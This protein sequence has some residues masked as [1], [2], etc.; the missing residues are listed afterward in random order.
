MFAHR[1]IRHLNRS[2][3]ALAAAVLVAAAIVPISLAHAGAAAT[4]TSPSVAKHSGTRP[5]IVLVHGAWADASSWGA[6]AAELQH[7][8]FTVD[9]APNPLRGLS[10][11]SGYLKDYLATVP[12]PI[13]LVGHS[14]GGAVITDAAKGNKKVKALVYD[15]AYIPAKGENVATLSGAD[16]AL[17]PATTDPTKVFK[18]APYP[19]APKGI[20]DTYVLPNVFIKGLA[21]DLPRKEAAV[22]AASQSPTSLLALGEPSSAPAWKTIPSWDLVGKQDRIIP[23]AQQLMMAHRAGSHIT[24]INSSHLSLISHPG[25]VTKVILRAIHAEG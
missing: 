12:G 9:V 23:L 18:L 5:T 25:A 20:Y 7:K 3:G 4:S 2:S 8:G 24:E 21:G 14:Y 19:G 1:K 11:D 10:Q 13:V 6:V 17:A 15:D 22:L 16:S